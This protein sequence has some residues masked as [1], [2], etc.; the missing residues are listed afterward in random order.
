VRPQ[1]SMEHPQPPVSRWQRWLVN[2]AAGACAVL[3]GL[4]TGEWVFPSLAGP[5]RTAGSSS[6]LAR[7]GS[8]LD[9]GAM[10]LTLWA[11]TVVLVALNLLAMFLFATFLV[12]LVRRRDRQGDLEKRHNFLPRLEVEAASPLPTPRAPVF[13]GSEIS[14]HVDVAGHSAE[15]DER[16]R[17]KDEILQRI[18]ESNLAL[19]S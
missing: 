5:S 13:T 4:T 10:G 3:L 8:P 14:F 15:Q 12:P 2:S 11:T 18:F 16:T 7:F 6:P 17:R 9:S 1:P 19:R